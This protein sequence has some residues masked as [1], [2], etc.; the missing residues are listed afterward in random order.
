M[1]KKQY[2]DRIFPDDKTLKARLQQMG[3]SDAVLK[4][5]MDLYERYPGFQVR[6][7]QTSNRRYVLIYPDPT[8]FKGISENSLIL[9]TCFFNM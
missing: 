3:A 4:S 8:D 6:K 9:P 7:A 5:F 1:K 2:E